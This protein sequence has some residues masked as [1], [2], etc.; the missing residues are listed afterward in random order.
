MDL[1]ERIQQLREDFQKS[2][3][4]LGHRMREVTG[5]LTKEIEYVYDDMAERQKEV[6]EAI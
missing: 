4:G 2:H 3:E 6:R 5:K 1:V